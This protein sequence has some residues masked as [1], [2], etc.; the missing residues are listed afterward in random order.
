MDIVR[1]L[2][3]EYAASIGDAICFQA[4]ERELA[5]L[6]GSYSPILLASDGGDLVGCV[7]LRGLGDG[8]GEMKRLYIRP[9]ARGAGLGRRLT[10]R[11]IA[12]AKARGFG[13]LRLDTLPSMERAIALYR[14]MGFREIPPYGGNP[15]EALCFELAL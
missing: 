9:G 6:P 15:P 11:I 10:E 4:F 2:F 1:A 3:R 8:C 7:A 5:G 12:E 13:A 14:A